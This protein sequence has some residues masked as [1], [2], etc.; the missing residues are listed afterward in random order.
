MTSE[1]KE[2]KISVNGIP[3]TVG[4]SMTVRVALSSLMFSMRDDG[5]GDDDHGKRMS[6][7]YA[8][9]A[10]EVLKMILEDINNG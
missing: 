4:Q 6:K 9:R 1:F 7:A 8:D 2:A 5:L 10:Q 3:L